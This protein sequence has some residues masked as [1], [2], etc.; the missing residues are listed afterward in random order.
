MEQEG[1]RDRHRTDQQALPQP[2]RRPVAGPHRDAGRALGRGA[3]ADDARRPDPEGGAAHHPRPPAQG[4]GPVDGAAVEPRDPG[5]ARDVP[6]ALRR[7]PASDR[8]GGPEPH[9]GEEGLF[10]DEER[11]II[12]PAVDAAK[13][14]GISVVGPISGDTVFHRAVAG[15][16]DVVIGMYHDQALIPLKLVDFDRAVNVTLGLPIVRTSVDHGTAYDIA[17]AGVASAH[18]MIEAL[19]LAARMVRDG[20]RARGEPTA[21]AD[22]PS[23]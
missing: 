17:G 18:S 2:G 7:P 6:R 14:Q 8:G 23:A 4:G 9:A 16:F 11:E 1:G 5:G 13:A 21:E 20:W 15:E 22:S 12:E 19:L 3:A 10:G